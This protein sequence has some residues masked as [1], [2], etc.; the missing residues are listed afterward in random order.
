MGQMAEMKVVKGQVFSGLGQG[1]V[2]TQLDWFQQ[3]CR[4]KLGF[5]P[6]PGTLNLKVNPEYLETMKELRCEAGIDFVPP[7]SDFCPAKGLPVS[8]GGVAAAIVIPEAE[9]FTEDVHSADVIEIIAPVHIKK[10]L[11]IEDGD[12]LSIVI[13]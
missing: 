7:S 9:S 5:V 4:D 1:G 12:E 11:S 10:A 13:E 6:F 3:Q 8:V 2:F